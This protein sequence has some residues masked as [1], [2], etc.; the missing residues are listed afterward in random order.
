MMSERVVR[1]GLLLAAVGMTVAAPVFGQTVAAGAKTPAFEVVSIKPNNNAHGMGIRIVD[2]RYSAMGGSVKGLIQYAY[3]IRM[4]DQVSGVPSA[5]D[6][7]RFDVE[8]K[9][10]EE[11][12]AAL[13]KLPPDQAAEQR[14]LMMQAMLAERFKLQVHHETKEAP[15]FALVIA[16]GGFKLKDA[17]PNNTYANG[18]KGPDGVGRKGMMMM[19]SGKLTAQAI[20]ISSLAANLMGQVH[21]V[22][23]DKTGLTGKYDFTL[24]WSPDELQGGGQDAGPSIFTA[25]E[26]QLGLKLEPIKGPVDTIVVDHVEMPTEN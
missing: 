22:V 1:R 18:M 4:T 16:K 26:E 14:R 24:Q 10:N 7:A 13:K 3:N 9:V 12:I 6:E 25:V 15:M 2:D 17:D 5:I 11:D 19:S 23:V 8:A 20:P 21:R